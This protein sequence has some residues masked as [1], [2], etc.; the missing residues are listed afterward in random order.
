M[1]TPRFSFVAALCGL[2]GSLFVVSSAVA[3]DEPLPAG[4]TVTLTSATTFTI[5]LAWTPVADAT[6]YLVSYSTSSTFEPESTTTTSTPDVTLRE[7]TKQ[8]MYYI[9]VKG[10]DVNGDDLTDWSAR[11]KA[12]TGPILMRVGSFNVKDPDSEADGS[13]RL[14]DSGRKGL[15][16]T[17]I[18]ASKVDVLGL[19]E[20]YE[21]KDRN[22]LLGA[23]RAANGVKYAMTPDVSDSDLGWDSRLLYDTTRVTLINSASKK[24]AKQDGDGSARQFVWG[25]FELK[26]NGHRFLVY[27]TH[28]EPGGTATLKKGQWDEIRANAVT[29]GVNKG[30]PV[31]ITGDYNTSKF[32][33]PADTMLPRMK[34]SGFGDVLGQTYQSYKVSGQRAKIRTNAWINSFNGCDARYGKVAKTAIGNNIDWIFA[35]NGLQIPAWRTVVHVNTSNSALAKTPM[36][37]DHFMVTIQALLP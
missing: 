37:S 26:A 19:Q 25:T 21:S 27:T 6:S 32:R 15:V 2:L 12:S 36:A 8:T 35:T 24:F 30:I 13:C 31:F 23:L 4:P 14:W 1:L 7:L 22:S 11:L 3:L 5:K 29:N 33:A 34:S 28:I 17:D 20:V 18:V 10:L 9:R 16:A